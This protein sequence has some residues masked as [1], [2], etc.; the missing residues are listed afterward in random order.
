MVYLITFEGGEGSGKT[1]QI[2]L[3]GDFLRDRGIPC[4]TTEEP[5]GTLLGKRVREILLNRN[6]FDIA[7]MTEL[8]LF[9]ASRYQHVESIIQP[10]L[11]A[12]NVVLCDRYTDATIAYQGFGRGIPREQIQILNTLASASLKPDRTFLFDMPVETGLARAARRM[13]LQQDRPREDRFE[14]EAIAFHQR[15]RNGYRHLAEEEP[16]RFVVLDAT[17]SISEIQEEIQ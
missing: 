6:T 17:R 1:T 3:A 15:V 16:E 2:A 10:A 9:Q 12:G 7:P 8:L 11:K 5:G 4:I 14:Q 13:D